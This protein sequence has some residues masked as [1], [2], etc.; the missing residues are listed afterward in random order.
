M[1][2][3]I[4]RS[5]LRSS[6]SSIPNCCFLL[7][8]TRAP[9]RSMARAHSLSPLD[10][11]CVNSSAA[12]IMASM[13]CASFVGR[14][15]SSTNSFCMADR[16]LDFRDFFLSVPPSSLLLLVRSYSG[17]K[18]AAYHNNRRASSSSMRG[19][20]SFSPNPF[21]APASNARLASHHPGRFVIQSTK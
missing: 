18:N 16:S 12:F 11:K 9:L 7:T 1:V 3:T 20:V 13:L 6:P 10:I 15:N 21:T 5:M 2:Q 19:S 14:F 4:R 17:F 8:T